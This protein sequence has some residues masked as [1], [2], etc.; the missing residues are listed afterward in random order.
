MVALLEAV[1]Y[2][3]GCDVVLWRRR[4]MCETKWEILKSRRRVVASEER[5]ESLH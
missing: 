3:S 5:V 4:R 1:S 2:G